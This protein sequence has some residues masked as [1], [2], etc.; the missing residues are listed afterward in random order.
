MSCGFPRTKPWS[1]PISA[2]LIVLTQLKPASCVVGDRGSELLAQITTNLTAVVILDVG[3]KLLKGSLVRYNQQTIL[4][5]RLRI[6]FGPVCF[7][8][9]TI[10]GAYGHVANATRSLAP[11]VLKVLKNVIFK[12]WVPNFRST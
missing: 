10:V 5:Y 9:R 8:I 4:N 12:L 11:Q 2:P 1:K 6:G 3:I 7:V